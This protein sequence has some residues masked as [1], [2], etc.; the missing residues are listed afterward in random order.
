M[1][2]FVEDR[3]TTMASANLQPAVAPARILLS[4]LQHQRPP[5]RVADRPS[6]RRSAAEDSPPLAPEQVA[7]PAE[8]RLRPGQERSPAWARI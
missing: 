1:R 6:A 5:L 3:P 8:Q 4:Q 2:L 7:M